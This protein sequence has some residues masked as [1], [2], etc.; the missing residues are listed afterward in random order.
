MRARVLVVLA[1]TGCHVVTQSETLRPE[2]TERI[3]RADAAHPAPPALVLTTTGELRFIEALRCATD[4]VVA[5]TRTIEIA[6]RPNLATFVVGAIATSIG[7]VLVVR[8]VAD[9]E[10]APFG[11]PGIALAGGGLPLA[12]GP[13][14][15]NGVERRAAR[16][17]PPV[18]RPGPDEPCGERP[19][20]ARSAVIHAGTIEMYGSIAGDGRFAI[21]PFALVDAFDATVGPPPPLDLRATLDDGRA[22]AAII[23]RAALAAAAPAFL[24]RGA[25][26]DMHVEPLRLVPD[27]VPGLRARVVDGPSVQLVV[28]LR[29]D[30]PGPAWAVRGHIVAPAVPAIDGRVVY[31]GAVAN[32]AT[33]NR[34]LRIPISDA[35]AGALRGAVDI[36]VELRDAHGTAPTT[37]ARFRGS[38]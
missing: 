18:R 10:L 27:L 8:A 1:V 33:L 23:D 13:W 2:R 4:E 29:N 34:E 15:G 19:L 3:R 35:A 17:A 24:A 32:G 7:G 28:T 5:R 38:L 14:I 12:I 21:S 36:S 6:T 26:V 9:R 22:I 31:I 16:D 30:G 11:Y 20:A 25:G 37:P